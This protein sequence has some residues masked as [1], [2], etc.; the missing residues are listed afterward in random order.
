MNKL[1]I[2]VAL[3]Y[4]GLVSTDGRGGGHHGWNNGG[5]SGTPTSKA[6]AN[7][8]V[9]QS[10]VTQMQALITQLTNNGSFTAVLQQRAQELAYYNNAANTPLLTS[11]C[12]QYF[13]GVNAASVLDNAANLKQRQY[14]NIANNLIQ[15]IFRSVGGYY[16]DDSH[17]K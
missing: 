7:A 2:V 17:E 14:T 15:G 6:C 1:I 9:A 5:S 11:N 12:T 3:V 4:L 8:T 10:V 16:N 13:A